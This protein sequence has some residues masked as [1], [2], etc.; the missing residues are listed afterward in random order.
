MIGA[1]KVLQDRYL[2]ND[3]PESALEP[4]SAAANEADM[5]AP[6]KPSS[7]RRSDKSTILKRAPFGFTS[8]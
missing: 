4:Q 2:I 7:A 6:E 8:I 3:G 1:H 5:G